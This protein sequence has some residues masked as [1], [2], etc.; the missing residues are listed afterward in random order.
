[1][2]ER[3]RSRPEML[4]SSPSMTNYER[5][6]PL[7]IEEDRLVLAGQIDVEP[8]GSVRLALGDQGVTARFGDQSEDRVGLVALAIGEVEPGRQTLQQPAA[9]DRER[10]MRRLQAVAGAGHAAGPDRAKAEDAVLV[11]R[12][13]TEADEM[14]V[15]GNLLAGVLGAGVATGGIGLPD[16]DHGVVDRRARSVVDAAGKRDD[17]PSGVPERFE[18]ESRKCSG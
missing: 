6:G 1:M 13:A 5:A 12:G 10:D 8:P 4:G 9:E 11:G 2:Q 3:A 7:H 15:E 18:P 16:L 17:L 14:P